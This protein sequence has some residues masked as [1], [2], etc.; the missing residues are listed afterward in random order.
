MID[1]TQLRPIADK[2]LI[3]LH[4]PNL[5]SDGGLHLLDSHNR[6]VNT[7]KVLALGPSA[8][9]EVQ[10]GDQVFFDVHCVALDA[11]AGRL[12]LLPADGILAILT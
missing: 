2:V 7:G 8:K 5:K 4:A 6:P 11:E 10:P 3:E 9:L 12:R 1:L